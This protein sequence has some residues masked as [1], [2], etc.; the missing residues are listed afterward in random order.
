MLP[1]TA[2]QQIAVLERDFGG[3]SALGSRHVD[4]MYLSHSWVTFFIL[5]GT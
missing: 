3:L 2:Q 1:S 4:N 5:K